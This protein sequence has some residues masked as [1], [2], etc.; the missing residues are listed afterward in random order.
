M[1]TPPP[2][3]FFLFAYNQEN[4]VREAC[5]AALAQTYTPLEIVLSDDCSSDRTFQI[6]QEVVANYSGP[7]RVRLNRNERNLGLIRHVNL[8]AE[9]ATTELIVVA[10]GD[11]ISLPE[12][13]ETIVQAYLDTNGRAFSIHSSATRIDIN[14]NELGLWQPPLS[15]DNPAPQALAENMSLLIGAT[16][17]WTRETFRVFGPI[18]FTDAYEDLVIAFRSAL[19][20]GIHY[21]DRPLVKYRV[22]NGIST[23]DWSPS[24]NKEQLRLRRLKLLRLSA[25]VLNQRRDDSRVVHQNA[26][27]ARLDRAA[28]AKTISLRVYERQ[29]PFFS[30]L[31]LALKHGCVGSFAKAWSRRLRNVV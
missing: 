7:H 19:L 20:G 14:G 22:G 13:T 6:M 15:D 9:L 12:R 3:T 23:A 17:A 8:S 21:I 27:A 4:Y 26:L 1:S 16:H 11:D 30:L 18:A 10:A 31:L 28:W 25:A 5:L 2:A 24:E 29:T